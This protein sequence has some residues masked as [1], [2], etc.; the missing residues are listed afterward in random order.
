MQRLDDGKT[1]EVVAMWA[2][3]TGMDHSVK[4]APRETARVWIESEDGSIAR[5]VVETLSE[6]GALIDL[7]DLASLDAGAEV[8]V[9]LSVDPATPTLGLR[10]RVL[11]V[12]AKGATSEC[13]L[14]WMPGPERAR[15]E[16]VLAALGEDASP[17][18]S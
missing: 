1:L 15:L 16:L 12:L 13:E 2:L 4:V 7:T 11:W 3:E 8:A 18:P 14:E 17:L 6:E 9:R 5:G 10:A